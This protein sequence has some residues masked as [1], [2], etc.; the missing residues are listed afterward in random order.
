MVEVLIGTVFLAVTLTSLGIGVL[1]GLRGTHQ[2]KEVNVVQNQAFTFMERIQH[3]RRGVEGRYAEPL[4]SRVCPIPVDVADADQLSQWIFPV[5]IGVTIPNGTH[6]DYTSPEHFRNPPS[7]TSSQVRPPTLYWM[8]HIYQSDSAL[9]SQ[10]E[11]EKCGLWIEDWRT[12][13]WERKRSRS[14]TSRYK[15]KN[16]NVSL[17]R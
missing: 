7:L 12:R 14:Y 17:S 10:M 16:Q 5:D 8:R 13:R 3:L 6:S 15:T 9:S 11:V 4:G 2:M 1:S